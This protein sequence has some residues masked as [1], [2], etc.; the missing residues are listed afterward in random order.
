MYGMYNRRRYVYKFFHFILLEL[1]SCRK[2]LLN[3]IGDIILLV[4]FV[5]LEPP[6]SVKAKAEHA[7]SDIALP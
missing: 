5:E 7:A 4:I 1:E 2:L 3:P 6:F